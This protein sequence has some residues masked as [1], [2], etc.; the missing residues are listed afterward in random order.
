MDSRKTGLWII[1]LFLLGVFFWAG[2]LFNG[3]TDKHE[4]SFHEFP[5]VPKLPKNAPAIFRDYD[6]YDLNMAGPER[7]KYI[8]DFYKAWQEKETLGFYEVGSGMDD[9]VHTYWL[10]KNGEV[11]RYE[12][13]D[14]GSLFIQK[15]YHFNKYETVSFYKWKESPDADSQMIDIDPNTIQNEPFYIYGI[16]KGK[17]ASF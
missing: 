1:M 12:I 2:Y 10:T 13:S 3:I 4:Y 17:P 6:F 11:F 5:S 8:H 7:N 14:H 9:L 15:T 16:K